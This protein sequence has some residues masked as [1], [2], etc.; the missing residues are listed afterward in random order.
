MLKGITFGSYNHH[1][2]DGRLSNTENNL[3]EM[4]KLY[5]SRRKRRIKRIH[6]DDEPLLSSVSHNEIDD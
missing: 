5:F 4:T 2:V 1:V 6:Y 3:L